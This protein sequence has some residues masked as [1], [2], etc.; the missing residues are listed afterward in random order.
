MNG[1]LGRSVSG[2]DLVVSDGAS[3]VRTAS[4]ERGTAAVAEESW[5]DEAP[6]DATM[7][8]CG[9]EEEQMVRHIGDGQSDR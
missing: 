6:P 3:R 4:E 5:P 2:S 9:T 8:G 1:L 7:E